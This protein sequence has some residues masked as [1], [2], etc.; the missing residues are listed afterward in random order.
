MR[1]LSSSLVKAN[2][3]ILKEEGNR[4]IDTNELV[5][6]K[7]ERLNFVLKENMVGEFA[8]GFDPDAIS[9]LL[10][11]GMNAD[12]LEGNEGVHQ[13]PAPNAEELVALA[14]S[15]IEQMQEEAFR[16]IEIQRQKAWDEGRRSGY[17]EGFQQAQMEEESKKQE[18]IE[19]E[20]SLKKR[21][22]EQMEALEPY[23]IETLT[24]IYEHIFQVDL[25]SNREL[26]VN[27]ISATMKKIEGN[28][29]FIVRV[30]K[31]DYPYVS[32]QKKQIVSNAVSANATVEII[33]DLVLGKNECLIETGGG[34]FDCS[35]GTELAELTKKL[36]LL[37]YE[38]VGES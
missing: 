10:Q 34:I 38:G 16:E 2:R 9:A 25:S 8:E 4:I 19:L 12:D 1:L 27:L 18:L 36:K 11:D 26:I 30:S 31:D 28:R 24:G 7:I 22:E 32:M 15:E 3:V 14:R 5:A 13:P 37:A 6:Q 35:L 23:F 20:H 21:Y 17:D 29:D 33:E